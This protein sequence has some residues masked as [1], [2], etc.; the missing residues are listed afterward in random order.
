MCEV[1]N[2]PGP[3]LKALKDETIVYYERAGRKTENFHNCNATKLSLG[4]NHAVFT[5]EI[6]NDTNK[7]IKMAE[8]SMAKA[9]AQI[10]SCDEDEYVEATHILELLKE[11]IAIWKGDDPTKV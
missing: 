2:T 5:A 9:V 7:A 4:L 1:N 10:N 6:L 8:L 3:K 11:N